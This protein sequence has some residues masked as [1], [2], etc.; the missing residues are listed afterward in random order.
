MWVVIAIQALVLAGIGVLIDQGVWPSG[1]PPALT[2]LLTVACA[3]PVLILFATD[4]GRVRR[5]FVFASAFAAILIPLAAY[6]GWQATPVGAFHVDAVFAVFV[7]T[8]LATVFIGVAYLQR[9]VAGEP[10]RYAALFAQAWRNLIVAALA[11]ALLGGVAILLA[12][13]AA[14]FAVLGVDAL[15]RTFPKPWFAMPAA[16]IAFGTGVTVFQPRQAL[17]DNIVGLIENLAR[18]LLP[19]VVAIIV[20]FLCTLPFVRLQTLWDTGNGSS[21]LIALNAIAIVL[22]IVAFRPDGDAPYPRPLHLAV[23]VAVALLPIVSA[24]ALLGVG[25][26]VGQYGWTVARAWAFTGAAALALFSLGYAWAVV[27]HRA[28]WPRGMAFVNV[29]MGWVILGVLLL[30]NTPVLDF[31]AISVRSQMARVDSGEIAPAEFDFRY[32]REMLARPGYLAAQRLIEQLGFDPLADGRATATVGVIAASADTDV[33]DRDFWGD[34]YY[35]DGPFDIPDGVRAAIDDE[36]YITYRMDQPTLAQVEL[37]SEST[38]VEYLLLGIDRFDRPAWQGMPASVS[39]AVGAYAI[40]E[41]DE[42]WGLYRLSRA[43]R[44][45]APQEDP[46]TVLAV[47]RDGAIERVRRR[48]D[49]VRIGEDVYGLPPGLSADEPVVHD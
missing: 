29:A 9:L 34:V 43:P 13:W 42:G 14:L 25:M 27:R 38:H 10:F 15:A 35:R 4:A 5:G 45:F 49:D 22:A 32:A 20:V 41:G 48:Y 6:V 24:L 28:D 26:R 18:Y 2:P 46:Q 40:V 19:L 47:L 21:I 1:S 3:W 30:V 36:A 17:I 37:D 16:A 7:P 31:R 12:L 11:A 39:Y 33:P 8:M 23:A 44:P